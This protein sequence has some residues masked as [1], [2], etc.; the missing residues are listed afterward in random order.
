MDLTRRRTNDEW[1]TQLATAGPARNAA[2]AD[3]R[4]ILLD[5]LRRGLTNHVNTAGPEFAPLAE[6]FVQEA[7]LKILANLDTFAGRS[8][9]TTWAHKITVRVALSELR[10]KR[11]RNVSFDDL[12]ADD[13]PFSRVFT[14]GT[15]S[16]ERATERADLLLQ[17]NNIIEQEL[18]DKQRLAMQLVPIGGLPVSEAAE[19]MGMK[20]NAFYKLLYDARL[21][22]KQRLEADGLSAADILATFR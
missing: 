12:I 15:P 7:L 16:P 6:D 8:L 19:R 17:L 14:A 18:T 1:L 20:R 22:V 10:R 5:G 9:F 2:L 21:R 13:T 3:L 11:W 4:V